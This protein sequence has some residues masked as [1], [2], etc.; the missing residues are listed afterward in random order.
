M[1]FKNLGNYFEKRKK[2]ANINQDRSDIIKNNLR[3]FLTEKFGENIK[4][5]S[6][7]IEY[8][9]KENNL[10]IT[11]GSKTIANELSFYLG[12]LLDFFKKEKIP[13]NRILI[14]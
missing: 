9:A 2:A 10:T 13:L 6:L 7:K 8:N 12:D 5:V 3:I 1:T 11:T 4:G 14:R